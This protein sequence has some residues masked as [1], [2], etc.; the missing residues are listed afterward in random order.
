LGSALDAATEALAS[1]HA[2]VDHGSV[3]TIGNIMQASKSFMFYP[4][5]LEYLIN[6]LY[7]P[8]AFRHTHVGIAQIW[9]SW[10]CGWPFMRH[11]DMHRTR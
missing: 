4:R 6:Q 9:G 10:S 8:L 7:R 2:G 5:A 3:A 1:L 11:L